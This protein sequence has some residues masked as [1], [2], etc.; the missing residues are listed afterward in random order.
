M[1]KDSA[2]H[3]YAT[4][5]DAIAAYDAANGPYFV[6][7]VGTAPTGWKIVTAGDIWILKKD[8]SGVMILTY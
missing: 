6:M 3:W 7:H 1:V 5:A 8:V 2:G 4:I